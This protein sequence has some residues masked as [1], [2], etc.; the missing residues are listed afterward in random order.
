LVVSAV[1][2]VWP[3]AVRISA[4]AAM[5]EASEGRMS[6]SPPVRRTWVM[7]SRSTPMRISRISSSSVS[8]SSRC[9]Q[10]IPPAGMQ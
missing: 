1:P 3:S 10:A 8:S 2:G 5:I 7:P 9:R 6:G 4:I